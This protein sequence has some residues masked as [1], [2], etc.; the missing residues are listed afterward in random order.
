MQTFLPYP[1][2][3]QTA[4]CL[5]NKRLIKQILEAVQIFNVIKNPLA[6]GWQKHPAVNQWRNHPGQLMSYAVC[7]CHEYTNRFNKIHKYDA[8][9]KNY[10]MNNMIGPSPKFRFNVNY[11]DN[12]KAILLGK[13]F[14]YYK[15]YWPNIHPAIKTNGKWPYIWPS[16][17]GMV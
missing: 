5:D 14:S 6:K 7:M 12:H 1:S 4:M 17:E 10:L 13:D 2:Y 8:Q 9:I 16:K 3:S 15:Y 11:L